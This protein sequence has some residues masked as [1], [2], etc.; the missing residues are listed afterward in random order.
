MVN[1]VQSTNKQYAL[2]YQVTLVT[3]AARN[4]PLVVT[5]APA[6]PALI[7]SAGIRVKAF[8]V[9]EPFVWS[10]I[11]IR[12]VLAQTTSRVILSS[13][14]LSLLSL[15]QGI[16]LKNQSILATLHRVVQELS[17]DRREIVP[18]VT[19]LR[20]TL[21]ILQLAVVLSVYRI[22]NVH[23]VRAVSITTA[24]IHAPEFVD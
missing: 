4:V 11:I 16:L 15:S 7:K 13:A 9:L 12:Y 22:P 5:V 17:A 23:A 18:L 1:A 14:V 8:A 24:S 3:L 2:A 19:A 21:A 6:Y 20:T 10:R